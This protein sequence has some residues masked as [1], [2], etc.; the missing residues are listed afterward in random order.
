MGAPGH[1]TARQGKPLDRPALIKVVDNVP[2]T[3]GCGVALRHHGRMEILRPARASGVNIVFELREH[4]VDPNYLRRVD[5]GRFPFRT[6]GSRQA[7]WSV[8][9]PG[10]SPVV[11]PPGAFRAP[12]ATRSTLS[13]LPNRRS[14]TVPTKEWASLGL[15][16][17]GAAIAWIGV[18]GT[19][20]LA[21]VTAGTSVFATA[22][23]YAG[24][25]AGTGQCLASVYRVGNAA[26][27]RSDINERLDK[28]DL[29]YWTMLAADGAGLAGVKG[30]ASGVKNLAGAMG[31]TGVSAGQLSARAMTGAQ[32]AQMT[33]ALG[34]QATK[35]GSRI[36][37][38]V[39]RQRLI[40]GAGA[41]L[42]IYSSADGGIVHELV[43]WAVEDKAG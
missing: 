12:P 13:K 34:L 38:R 39:V 6:A 22:V 32:R 24:A 11:A 37:N 42:G 16:C 40:E 8:M 14:N 29:Y 35:V 27:G 1:T 20:A 10:A 33:A 31:R 25:V 7:G 2:A 17:G 9:R 36:I 21:P 43:V 4:Y 18:V 15:N 23:M 19:G 5:T 41:V 3:R 28:S 30:A 26:R